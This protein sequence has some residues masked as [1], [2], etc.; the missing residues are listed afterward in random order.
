MEKNILKRDV[1][2]VLPEKSGLHRREMM[3]N[4]E[5]LVAKA[6]ESLDQTGI[7]VI[8]NQNKEQDI[9]KSFENSS[10]ASHPPDLHVSSASESQYVTE[11]T[12]RQGFSNNASSRLSLSS[13]NS[14]DLVSF[15]ST[16]IGEEEDED[17]ELE[18]MG[19]CGHDDTSTFSPF[20]PKNRV[21]F[22]VEM[23]NEVDV[24][25]GT[26]KLDLYLE[27]NNLASSEK[28][29]YQNVD[30]EKYE[31]NDN[32]K[33]GT[34]NDHFVILE[35]VPQSTSSIHHGRPPRPRPQ[36]VTY[37][38]KDEIN[39]NHPV[40]NND[41]DGRDTSTLHNPSNRNIVGNSHNL[42]NTSESKSAGMM[43]MDDKTIY[44][45][46]EKSISIPRTPT[47]QPVH[48]NL[49]SNVE[50][51]VSESSNKEV[52]HNK[53]NDE[54]SIITPKNES[55]KQTI[56]A[57]TDNDAKSNI[58]SINH[59]SKPSKTYEATTP[60]VS[61][62]HRTYAGKPMET[63]AYV[64][65]P[66]VS[67]SSKQEN[68]PSIKTPYT[69]IK[70]MTCSGGSTYSN[71]SSQN[72]DEKSCKSSVSQKQKTFGAS[73]KAAM[74]EIKDEIDN[75]TLKFSSMQHNNAL[76]RD[77]EDKARMN[78]DE[79]DED[80]KYT[81]SSHSSS[82]EVFEQNLDVLHN[83]AQNFADALKRSQEQTMHYAKKSDLLEQELLSMHSQQRSN[84]LRDSAND[85]V[86]QHLPVHGQNV[87]NENF[88]SKM[89][90]RADILSELNPQDEYTQKRYPN[91]PKTP[92]TMFVT[93]LT[94]NITL[95]V[96]EH[97]YLADIMDRQWGSSS[98]YYM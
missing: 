15:D 93:E 43:K 54:K 14:S 13:W 82:Q 4:V 79:D 95:D 6:K 28:N 1:N 85:V 74:S 41:L 97:A 57:K 39:L 24:K 44:S 73:V 11:S 59:V 66:L 36:D 77:K 47:G 56:Q 63:P 52:N 9:P 62:T 80:E 94:E 53:T 48:P 86:D 67:T 87:N 81:F 42:N 40:V 31:I 12:Q 22:S 49:N 58:C 7:D 60:F 70:P 8:E 64:Y 98:L 34:Q 21:P 26:D 35:N 46:N 16:T 51:N 89:K 91:V 75:L 10:F 71:K 69:N 20:Y 76:S 88:K 18:I 33:D 17:D 5:G 65:T 92:G 37:L 38:V 3:R 29:I 19:N 30:I 32:N 96:G 83:K 25:D 68:Y 23:E 50:I 2:T 45:V 55:S 78:H 72:S 61:I 84:I 27:D 90:T